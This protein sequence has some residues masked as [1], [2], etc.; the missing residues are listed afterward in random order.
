MD[1]REQW[2]RGL[3]L[4]EGYTTT[5]HF[6]HDLPARVALYEEFLEATLAALREEKTL[7][8]SWSVPRP[9]GTRGYQRYEVVVDIDGTVMKVII[10]E[11]GT[12]MHSIHI[13]DGQGPTRFL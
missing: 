1:A 2:V 7:E 4:A 6:E 10:A 12:A 5:Q 11:F 9:T 8:A 3:L 13:D